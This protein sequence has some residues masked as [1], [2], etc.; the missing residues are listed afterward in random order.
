MKIVLVIGTRP[1]FMKVAPIAAQLR[2]RPGEFSVRIVH[3]GQHYDHAMSAVFLN[4]LGMQDPDHYLGAITDG[5]PVGQVADIMSKFDAVLEQEKPELVMVVGDV[6]STLACA[7]VAALRDLPLAHVEAGL[8][9]GDRRLP[10]ELYRIA[11]DAFADIL[12]TYSAD[13]DANLEAEHV[14]ASSIFRVGNV[15]IDALMQMLPSAERSSILDELGLKAGEYAVATLHRQSNVENE[16]TLRGIM[17]AFGQI[18]RRI[19]LVFQI[20]P[21]TRKSLERFVL[22]TAVAQMP[23]LILREPM[24]YID[25]LKLQKDA[26]MALVD[27][28]GIQ[29]ETTVLG[30]PCLTLRE[31]TERPITVTEGTNTIVGCDREDIVAAAEK[32]LDEGGKTGAVPELWDGN[33]AQRLVDVLEQHGVFRR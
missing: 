27:S 23:G 12:F 9:S 25:F 17:E 16:V 15:M 2:Q 13:A 7:T 30:V 18:Q 20:H 10:E 22:Y 3:T 1:N 4:E 28:G 5:G 21:R 11:T 32:V 29:E 31:S 6:T 24:G 14:P 26:R 8:R 19:P 33:S